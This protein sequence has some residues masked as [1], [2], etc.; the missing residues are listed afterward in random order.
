[1]DLSGAIIKHEVADADPL[2][3]DEAAALLQNTFCPIRERGR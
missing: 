1:M 2:D 3:Y